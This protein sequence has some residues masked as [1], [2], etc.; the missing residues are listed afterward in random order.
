MIVRIEHYRRA[1]RKHC[2]DGLELFCKK[3][4]LDIDSIVRNG[5][6]SDKLRETGSYLAEKVIEEAEKDGRK[7]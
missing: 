3:Y 6:D 2:N 4:G 7:K 5:I 1:M